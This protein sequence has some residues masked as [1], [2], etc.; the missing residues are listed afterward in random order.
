MVHTE[1]VKSYIL[2]QCLSL[3][4]V[5]VWAVEVMPVVLLAV[6]VMPVVL[7]AVEV[8]LPGGSL[9]TQR[10][11]AD[12]T[13]TPLLSKPLAMSGRT[14]SCDRAFS[15]PCRKSRSH[16]RATPPTAPRGAW[17]TAWPLGPFN[18]SHGH[19]AHQSA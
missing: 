16:A 11:I 4:L 12:G 10:S 7:L 2:Y 19:G 3:L 8:T 18:V 14:A 9:L 15:S 13:A 6:E 17:S 5:M 1:L